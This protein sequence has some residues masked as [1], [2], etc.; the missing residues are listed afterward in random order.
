[1]AKENRKSKVRL[2]EFDPKKGL[3]RG[4]PKWKEILWYVVKVLFFTSPLP[5]PYAFKCGLLRI[6][7]A[8]IG[9]QVVI[10]PKVNIHFPWKLVLGNNVWIGEEVFI[11]NFESLR[12][13]N[14]VCISQRTFLCGGNHN[15]LEP[16][17]PYRNGPITLMDG[18]WVGANCF[19]GPGVTI[20]ID[21]VVTV[22]SQ[23]TG[24]LGDNLVC[25]IPVTPSLKE[26]WK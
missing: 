23:V 3:E 24:S 12:I 18:C 26:R 6:F 5:Y 22:G 9:R 20:G 21:T 15:Y 25:S 19:V 13:G 4:A 7:G 10:K 8:Q 16:S 1:M 2:N 14:N 17:M 11:L